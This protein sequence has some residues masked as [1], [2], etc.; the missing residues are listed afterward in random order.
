MPASVRSR[1]KEVWDDR[2][3]GSH[4]FETRFVGFTLNDGAEPDELR[5]ALDAVG[6]TMRSAPMPVVINALARLRA[7][8]KA[9]EGQADDLMAAAYTEEL[10]A[11]PADIVV[12]ACKSVA[13]DSVFFPAWAEL[14]EAC[15]WRVMRRRR[16]AEAL[17]KYGKK[18]EAA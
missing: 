6:V 11:Y 9:R 14:R 4:G 8:T 16:L 10:A 3:G 5:Q 12:D 13:K 2:T 7:L 15:E 18:T 1:L 17:A